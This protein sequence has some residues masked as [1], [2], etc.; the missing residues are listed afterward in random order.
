MKNSEMKNGDLPA[1]PLGTGDI[2]LVQVNPKAIGLTKRESFIKAAM[3]G[4]LSSD[5]V[6]AWDIND[7][8]VNAIAQAD[9]VLERLEESS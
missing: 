2:H 4:L 8:A 9:A 3:Q 1:Y 7:V 6:N 5:V